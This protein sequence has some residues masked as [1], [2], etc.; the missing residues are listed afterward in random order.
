MLYGERKETMPNPC[1]VLVCHIC[2]EKQ[3]L[4]KI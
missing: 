4:H 2:E 3:N 1:G